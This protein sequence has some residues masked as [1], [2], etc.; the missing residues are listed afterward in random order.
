MPGSGNARGRRVSRAGLP[1]AAPLPPRRCSA[2]YFA[3]EFRGR[4]SVAGGRAAAAA[5]GG[6]GAAGLESERA[7]RRAQRAGARRPLAPGRYLRGQRP[8]DRRHASGRAPRSA[9]TPGAASSAR[10][11]ALHGTN[12]HPGTQHAVSGNPRH[13]R[14]CWSPKVGG[15]VAGG[16]GGTQ[17]PGSLAPLAWDPGGQATASR[18]TSGLWSC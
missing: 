12:F 11:P 10:R 18:G 14:R 17:R 13:G 15:R 3:H 16:R 2:A 1:G 8:R 9:P 7:G 4:G 5:R 6:V